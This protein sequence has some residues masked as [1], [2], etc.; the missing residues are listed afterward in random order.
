MAVHRRAVRRRPRRRRRPACR[1]PRRRPPQALAP[2]DGAA[3]DLAASSSAA[4][5]PDEVGA[6][7]VRAGELSGAATVVG[8][9]A[10]GVLGGGRG[11]ELTS[12]VSV[13]VGRAA[14]RVGCGPSTSRCCGPRSRS[15]SSGCRSAASTTGRGAAGRPLL[16]PG[17]RASSSR[18]QRGAGRPAARRRP[19]R[20]AARRR[21]DPAARRRRACT[22]GAPSAWCSAARLAHRAV[23]SQGC[24]PVGPAMT[25]TAAEGNVLLGAG[26]RAGARPSS[27]R[28][29]PRCRPQD[30]AL[31]SRRDCTSAS[32]WTSTPRSTAPAT[33]WCA[34]SSVSTASAAVWSSA[35]SSTVGQH[36][37][38]SRCATPT[39]DADLDLTAHASGD[40]AGRRG[41]RAAVLLQRAR[42]GA[43]R[44][45]G[46]RRAAVR[47]VLGTG[48]VA[49][50]F[51]AGEIGPV[52]GRNHL[53]GFTASV[54]VL[55]GGTEPTADRLA[56]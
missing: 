56:H 43:V 42:G 2:L 25:V 46:P 48:G 10:P 19:R 15:R 51:A 52:G 35:T 28:C 7:L 1:P 37:A 38:A 55:L 8:C 23:V 16:V 44:H 9:S 54:L 31:V 47:E 4:P 3:P 27:R 5:E 11:V 17:R 33:S 20:R 41:R 34:A 26:R 32:P 40:G 39:R 29:S 36:G 53:H 49:G 22:T 45:R 50:F 21:L 6:A 14:G 13:W 24:R 12:A 30:Q 18:R